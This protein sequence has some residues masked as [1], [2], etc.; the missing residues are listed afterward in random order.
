[1]LW[2]QWSEIER[3]EEELAFILTNIIFLCY[4][5][6]IKYQNLH[7]MTVCFH[8]LFKFLQFFLYLSNLNAQTKTYKA[9]APQFYCLLHVEPYVTSQLAIHNSKTPLE[10]VSARN[11]RPS[12]HENKPKTLVLYDWK[13]AYW[14][15]FREN[16]VYKFGHS[17]DMD[18]NFIHSYCVTYDMI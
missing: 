11:Y 14:A 3:C 15:C 12:F 9:S 17:T 7:F 4:L 16:W 5:L 18:V 2:V 8:S 13:R 6:L 1:M 10:L